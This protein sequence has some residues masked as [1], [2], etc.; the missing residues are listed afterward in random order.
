MIAIDISIL[1]RHFCAAADK[2]TPSTFVYLYTRGAAEKK[3]PSLSPL[4][5][6][7]FRGNYRFFLNFDFL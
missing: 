6:S 1:G 7:S 4:S 3:F 2:N 5:F